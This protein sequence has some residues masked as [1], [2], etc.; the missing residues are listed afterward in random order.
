MKIRIGLKHALLAISLLIFGLAAAQE[1][2]AEPKRGGTLVLG[3]EEE[4][5]G[6]D[7]NLVTAFSSIRRVEL[8]YNRLVR[9]NPSAEIVP[10]LAESW[11][12]TDPTTYVFRLREGVMFHDGTELDAE[13]VKFT[14]ERI[15]N[16]ESG[17]PARSFLDTVDSI[18]VLDP[19]TVEIKLASPTAS[20][21]DALAHP[22][23][24]IVSREAVAEHGDLQRTAVGTGPF[25]LERW[26]PDQEMALVRNPDYF[27]EGLPYLDGVV[28]RVI[29]EQASLLAGLR[30]GTLDAAM[31][32]DGS[33]LRLAER[34]A[35]IEVLSVPS[36]NMRTYGFNT[37]RAPFDDARVRRA[38]ALAIDRVQIIQA[39]ELGFGEATAPL[40]SSATEWAAPLADLPNYQLDLETARQLLEE[41][42]V[43]PGTRFNIVASDSYEGG[44]AVAEVIQQQL[45]QIGLEAQL[46]VVEWG[47][48]IDRWVNR[49]FDSMVELRGGGADP[50]RF[51]YRLIHSQGAVNNF[52]YGNEELDELLDAGRSSI[53]PAERREAYAA[54]QELLATEFPYIAL[55][56]PVQTMAVRQNVHGFEL[57]PNGSFRYLAETWLDE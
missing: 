30:S 21:L 48:Y 46:E 54:A 19:L 5:I 42:G 55:Y 11:E 23:T 53:D 28:I 13:D 24:S 4:A 41:A 6:L 45:R 25:E 29:P 35:D 31:L 1:A 2:A 3:V 52:L 10:D 56:T 7:P 9:Y 44:L 27:E 32:T 12:A 15:L 26:T 18:S 34:S 8:L 40:P 37:T 38:I 36:L 20:L 22:N 14:L 17:S 50:D 39:A 43:A 33:V 16:P 47:T 49:D 51:L 57:V